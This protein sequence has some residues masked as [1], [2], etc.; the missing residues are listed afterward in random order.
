MTD[1]IGVAYAPYLIARHESPQVVSP[2]WIAGDIV[3]GKF[4]EEVVL[5]FLMCKEYSC[6]RAEGSLLG[7]R[8]IDIPS[9]SLGTSQ[10]HKSSGIHLV[11]V[12]VGLFIVH[13]REAVVTAA[14][15]HRAILLSHY[16]RACEDGYIYTFE[17]P[18]N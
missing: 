18:T 8:C 17:G 5:R 16:R 15:R 2:S 4:H 11:T 6:A 13:R 3:E 7:R 12:T 14:G 10:R 1:K 9:C